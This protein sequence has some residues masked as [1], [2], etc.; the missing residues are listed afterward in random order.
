MRYGTRRQSALALLL[1]VG[2]LHVPGS[3]ARDRP[4]R[5]IEPG[6]RKY[7]VYNVSLT[8]VFT[9]I[10]A[11]VQQHVLR[12]KD[13]ARDLLIGAAAGLSF[14]QAKRIT[15]IGRTTEGWLLANVTA[16]AVENTAS[17]EHPM[18]RVGYTVG[19]F[20]LRFAT[21]LARKAIANIEADWSVAETAFMVE[22]R[23]K[24][25]HFHIR[26][27]LIAIDRDTPW[28]TKDVAGG[29]FGGLTN[30]VFPGLAPG[31]PSVTWSHEMVHAIQVQQL[32]SVEPSVHVFGS[33][34][35]SQPRRL[36]AFRNVRLGFIQMLNAPTFRRPYTERW[37]EVEAYGLA[38]RT[39][40]YP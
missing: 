11:R 15:G 30:G 19:P 38:Q 7:L 14:Y 23:R 6:K 1:V 34:D 32:D 33:S 39:P 36:F 5:T 40:V 10:S 9:L 26:H 25:D 12:P 18:G 24:G 35:P 31:Q 2:L 27:G 16:S 37:G 29:F 17:G 4:I 21:P 13:V 22:G 8:S 3:E 28:P 20:R